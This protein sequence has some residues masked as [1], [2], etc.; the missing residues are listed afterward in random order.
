M[1]VKMTITL[2]FKEKQILAFSKY[3]RE[4]LESGVFPGIGFN[5]K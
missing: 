5:E 3:K 2:K 4:T 1:N